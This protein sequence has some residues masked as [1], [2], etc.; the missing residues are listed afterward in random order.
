MKI[1]KVTP[2]EITEE[3]KQ[4]YL[5][6]A[7]SVIVARAL[8]DIRDGLKPVHRRIFYAMQQM[9]QSYNS[10]YT[11]SAKV[12]GETMGKYHPHGDMAIY[13]A[14][15]RL[16]Q[17]FSMRYPLID[18]HG[19]FGSVDG[20]SAAAMRYTEVRM[21]KI[22]AE[23]LADLEKETVD[24]VENF[25]GSLKEP[26]YL[27][28]KLPNLLLMGSD[29]IAVGMATKIPPHNLGEVIDALLMSIE[30]G[31]IVL[32]EKR[33]K[34]KDDQS[35]VIKKIK[36]DHSELGVNELSIPKA[37]FSSEITLEKLVTIIKGPDFPTGGEIYDGEQIFQAYS[38][39]KGKII[40]RAKAVIQENKK[41]RFQII[42]SEIPYQ[43]NKAT[44]VTKIAHLIKDKKIRD[45][46][47]LRDESDRQGM[48]I[49]LDL[50]RTAK[51]K[52]VLN[53]LYKFTPMQSSYPVNIVAL[54]NGVPQSL[55]LKQILIEFIKHRQ[56]VITK[57]SLFD[58]RAAKKRAH[59]LEGLKIAL[60]N[61][62][63]V[64]STIRRSRDVNTARINLIKK[65]KLTEMQ[66]N[67]ILEMQLRRLA[68]LER[69][70]IEDEYKQIGKQILF[71]TELLQKPEKILN[72]IKKEL[73]EI[74]EKYADPRRTKVFQQPVGE[75]S[76]ADL[77]PAERCLITVTRTGYIKRLPVG[78]YRSQRRGGKGVIGM[79]TKQEDEIAQ[80]FIANT[81]DKVLF[82][83][84]RG[85]VF[86]VRAWE[87]PEG[88]RTSRGQAVI[89]LINIDQGEEVQ[90]ILNLKENSQN[91]FLFMTTK[92]GRVKKTSL[93]N[94][95]N[96]R[97]SGLIAIKLS[98]KDELCWVK[99]TSGEDQILLISYHGKSIRF[100]EKD[101][102][103]MGRDTMGVKGIN[104][105]KG[106]YVIGMEVFKAKEDRP[107]D[108]R[109]KFFRNFLI[110]TEKGLGKRTAINQWPLQKRGGI[111][112][113]AA[114]LTPK[115]GRIVAS[116]MVS[117][118]IHQI[119][120]TSKKAQVIKL[121]L[122]NIPTL[123]RDTQGVI[124]MRFSKANDTIAAVTCLEK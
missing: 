66:A 24:F 80:M 49:V 26:V 103:P 64:I 85:R 6:Y 33:K 91:G 78:T 37:S 99:K 15:V 92:N 108:K 112:V 8:P 65:F 117:Q 17:E 93:D 31:Q 97:T 72:E 96:I 94:F 14:L 115:T 74:K 79:K 109:R 82:F 43:V 44:L 19:N 83:T 118:K 102:R 34:G 51:P 2:V 88:T 120:L 106:D 63:E 48:R 7:M 36:F 114:N 50:K 53:S 11:K 69:Q 56:K 124:L 55:N 18:G 16:A 68:A 116:L 12:V 67:A 23:M 9:G 20:D 86:A 62:D 81:H 46:S 45:I 52:A 111:G 75:F 58:L 90:A 122:K 21:H 32:S 60:D 107:K 27:P 54:V 57:R 25:D 10:A 95:K 22:T 59:I 29:G 61:L 100:D 38:T 119:I 123:G 47:G 76:Q 13:D 40:M 84:N 87:L 41:N 4:S 35:F 105:K 113:K 98:G 42:V 5:D 110:I 30:N 73:R 77:V 28:A 121:P 104:L 101:A 89:N 70:K 3:M 1:G 39:G 71:L